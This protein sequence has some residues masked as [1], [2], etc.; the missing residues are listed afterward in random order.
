[1]LL[2]NK[3]EAVIMLFKTVKSMKQIRKTLD[4]P[5]QSLKE[6]KVSEL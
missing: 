1:M 4:M 5:R 2:N 6:T 3:Q